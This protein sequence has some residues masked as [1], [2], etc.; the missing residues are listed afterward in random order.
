MALLG[1]GIAGCATTAPKQEIEASSVKVS[2]R[3]KAGC[4]MVGKV[5]ITCQTKKGVKGAL[6]AKASSLGANFVQ[7]RSLTVGTI[8]GRYKAHGIAYLCRR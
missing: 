6:Q 1:L 8:T 7:V 2:S 5:S 3:H 4:R